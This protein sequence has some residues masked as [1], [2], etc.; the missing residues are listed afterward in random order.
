MLSRRMDSATRGGKSLSSSTLAHP[1]R[2]FSLAEIQYANENFHDKLV[3]GK[4]GF[5]TVY[6]GQ[7]TSEEVVHVVAIKRWNPLSTQ[8]ELRFRAEIDILR[9]CRH[10]H[11]VSLIGYC[12]YNEEKIVV[13]EYMPNGSLYHHLYQTSRPLSW[14]QRL[15]IAIGAARGLDYL[16]TRV[17]TQHGVIH[18]DVKS[19]TILLDDNWEAV[20]SDLGVSIIG[21][22]W[23]SYVGDDVKGTYGYLDPEYLMT[24]KLTYKTDVYAFGI[25]LFELLAGRRVLDGTYGDHRR[26]AIWVQECVKEGNLD[27]MVDPRIKG[28]I[29]TK[30]LSRFAQI[31]ERC[32]RNVSKERPTMSELVASL[33]ALLE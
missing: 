30:C 32:V 20:I 13:Y 4:G 1:C 17:S 11:L 14:V 9:K 23:N 5:G 2:L 15:N 28:E 29:S 6:K 26:L 16:H 22:T 8:G 31:A 25:V 21:P 7:I 33:Q 10:C 19:S 27:Q 3:T 24:G 18:C 12:A